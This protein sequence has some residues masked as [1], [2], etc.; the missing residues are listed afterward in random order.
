[1]IIGELSILLL[2]IIGIITGYI[3]IYI[4]KNIGNILDMDNISNIISESIIDINIYILWLDEYE[5]IYNRYN[6]I[7]I[8][9]LLCVLVLISGYNIINSNIDSNIYSIEYRVLL[10]YNNIY[11]IEC[12]MYYRYMYIIYIYIEEGILEIGIYSIIRQ[13]IN[14]Y[15]ILN[16]YININSYIYYYLYYSILTIIILLL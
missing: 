8:I 2:Y 6:Y 10:I 15:S 11:N 7:Y 5:Y 14:K 12:N 13:V 16:R 9:W 4:Y 1:M 3:Y